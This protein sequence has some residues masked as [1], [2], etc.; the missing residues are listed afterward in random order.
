VSGWIKV[1]GMTTA[2]GVKAAVEAG[3]DAIGFVFAPSARRVTINRACELA[4][5]MRQ[6]VTIVAV[7]LHPTRQEADEIVRDFRPHM[8][9][10]DAEDYLGLHMPQRL[11]RLPVLRIAN[12]EHAEYP[13][14]VLFEGPKS[15]TG[16]VADWQQ[17]AALAQRTRLVLA[18]GLNPGNVAE[19]IRIVRPYGVD[20][21]SGVESRPGEKSP[22]LI[23][24][25][26][27]AARAAFKETES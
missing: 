7:T 21:S 12:L 6:R 9:Q 1:C 14:R 2:A 18:G 4:H 19:A 5:G 27:S 24:Q 23:R 8:L 3:A 16:Q 20:V 15:G 13:P 26:I 22:E 17:A 11:A 25:F 10:A